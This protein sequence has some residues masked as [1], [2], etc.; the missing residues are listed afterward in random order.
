MSWGALPYWMYEV[1]YEHHV[2]KT[3]CCFESEWY[4]ATSKMSPPYVQKYNSFSRQE[5]DTEQLLDYDS[6]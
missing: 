2:A 6:L 1:Q 3:Q 5:K 4:S